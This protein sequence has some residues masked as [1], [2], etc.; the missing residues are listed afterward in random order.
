[1]LRAAGSAISARFSA[2]DASRV[3]RSARPLPTARIS[4]NASAARFHVTG[5][6]CVCLSG[7]GR[8]SA[9][10]ESRV[11]APRG[12]ERLFRLYGRGMLSRVH[13]VVSTSARLRA[14]SAEPRALRVCFGR[15][16]R[17][18][19]ASCLRASP[20]RGLRVFALRCGLQP[21][22]RHAEHGAV[23]GVAQGGYAP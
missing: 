16:W 22:Q 20:T 7:S 4:I 1:M 17:K 18:V 11:Y 10:C 14:L 8:E 9:A 3:S 19:Q 5:R 6:R 23:L 12:R 15:C 21:G 13:A 2:D